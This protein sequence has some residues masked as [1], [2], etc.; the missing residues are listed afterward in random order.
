M[1]KINQYQNHHVIPRSM[2]NHPTLK[3]AGFNIDA[4]KNLIY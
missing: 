4:P 2:A 1:P 3:A